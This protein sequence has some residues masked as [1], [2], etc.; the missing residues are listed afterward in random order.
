MSSRCNRIAEA[1]FSVVLLYPSYQ[2]PI[3]SAW[4]FSLCFLSNCRPFWLNENRQQ[5]SENTQEHKEVTLPLLKQHNGGAAAAV[6]A[7]S[8]LDEAQLAF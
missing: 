2:A 3:L 6:T 4:G 8:E 7:L 1:F 5:A